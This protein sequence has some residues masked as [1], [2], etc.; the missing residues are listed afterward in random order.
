MSL[1]KSTDRGNFLTILIVLTAIGLITNI[2]K[3]L[4]PTDIQKVLGSV[5]SWYT[6]LNLTTLVLQG[7][8]LVGIWTWKKWAIY[9]LLLSYVLTTINGFLIMQS[10]AGGQTAFIFVLVITVISAGL[11]FWALSRKWHLFK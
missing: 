5:P 10:V 11:W 1:S 3:T 6:P 8:A 4:S 7:V 2:P 9:T